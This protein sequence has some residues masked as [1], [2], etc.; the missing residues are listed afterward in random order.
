M[1][2]NVSIVLYKHKLSEIIPLVETLRKSEAVS[3]IFLIDNSPTENPEFTSLYVNY[4]FTGK[5]IGYGAGHN[6]AIKQTLEQ[7]ISYH[8][9]INPDINFEPEILLKIE[10]FMN[11]NSEIG[12]LMPKIRYPNGEIQYLCKLIPTPFDLIFRRFLPKSWTT[13]RTEKFELRASGYN[14]MLEVPYLSGCFMFLKTEAI[15]RVG[16]FDERFFM[17]P[18]DIDLSRR[19]HRNYKT[20]YYPNVEVVH[21][22]EQ[23][24]YLNL[25]MLIIHSVNMIKYFNKWGWI[26][27]RNR[28]KINKNTLKQLT[29]KIG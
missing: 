21:F 10:D 14:R 12:L 5:N 2:V 3:Q 22:H 19:I 15:R 29:S 7:N 26:F 13:K 25:K 17:Y 4:S 6:I 23:S 18:E 1:S 9:V 20:I 27:D 16:L 24:S 28:R 11:N 8:L